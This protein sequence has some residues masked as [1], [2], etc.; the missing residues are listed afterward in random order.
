MN[1][2][3]NLVTYSI[4]ELRPTIPYLLLQFGKLLQLC[5][6]FVY[7]RIKIGVSCWMLILIA[8][9]IINIIRIQYSGL[10]LL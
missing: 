2:Y 6:L 7:K 1:A 3:L 8:I 9:T 10:Q 4:T 5:L